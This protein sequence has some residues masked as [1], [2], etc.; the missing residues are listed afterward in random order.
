MRKMLEGRV[1]PEKGVMQGDSNWREGN[2]TSKKMSTVCG[3]EKKRGRENYYWMRNVGCGVKKALE[4]DA[5]KRERTSRHTAW[6]SILSTH[7]YL[8]SLNK[9]ACVMTRGCT[10]LLHNSFYCGGSHLGEQSH[11][12]SK[13]SSVFFCFIYY[14]NIIV[15][16]YQPLGPTWK[17]P[18]ISTSVLICITFFLQISLSKE[19]VAFFSFVF[20]LLRSERAEVMSRGNNAGQSLSISLSVALT[21]PEFFI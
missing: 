4:G 10:L 15:T 3:E 13:S 11:P 17:M 16:I 12:F 14:I 18:F 5:D 19:D 8:E 21:H 9:I 1:A 7:A 20:F 6:H 2:V